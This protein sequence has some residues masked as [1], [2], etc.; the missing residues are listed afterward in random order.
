MA[1]GGL[2]MRCLRDRAL[3]AT[4][5][6]IL[7]NLKK[8]AHSHTEIPTPSRPLWNKDDQ[9]CQASFGTAFEK[10]LPA[11]GVHEGF[12]IPID[13]KD[14]VANAIQEVASDPWQNC[15]QKGQP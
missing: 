3:H 1:L 5:D 13:F 12:T 7:S 9:R 2:G 6:I 14:L 8:N 4:L 15:C 10:G 11:P